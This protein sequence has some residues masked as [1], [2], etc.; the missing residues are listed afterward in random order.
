MATADGRMLDERIA[1][2]PY[3]ALSWLPDGSG[4]FYNRFA[5][6]KPSAPDY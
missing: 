2:A 1:D 6:R 3:P 4:F 5:G